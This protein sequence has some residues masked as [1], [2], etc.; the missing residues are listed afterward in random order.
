M[1]WTPP[2]AAPPSYIWLEKADPEAVT[3]ALFLIVC[4]EWIDWQ[5]ALGVTDQFYNPVEW[6]RDGDLQTFSNVVTWWPKSGLPTHLHAPTL[7]GMVTVLRQGG[8]GRTP[9]ESFA[10]HLQARVDTV[11]AHV[12]AKGGDT[13]NPNETSEERARR[14]N[15]ERQAKFLIAHRPGSDDPAHNALIEDAKL[16]ASTLTEWKAYLRKYVKEQK[17][18]CAA[19]ERAA[20]QRRDDN[21]RAAEQAI[22]DQETRML[23]AKDAVIAYKSN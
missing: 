16:Q 18:E 4:N 3:Y 9:R 6:V 1:T 19:A 5:R 13:E 10:E 15:R 8:T 21:I 22:V 17:L 7:A 14:K 12:R 11:K 23:A 2:L 20:K